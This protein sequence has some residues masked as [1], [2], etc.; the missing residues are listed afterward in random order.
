MGSLIEPKFRVFRHST[1]FGGLVA[2]GRLYRLRRV[3]AL[4][5]SCVE[6][7]SDDASSRQPARSFATV[8]KLMVVSL[9]VMVGAATLSLI[10]CAQFEDSFGELR[11]PVEQSSTPTISQYRDPA[12]SNKL[13][14]DASYVETTRDSKWSY[15]LSGLR[16]ELAL[17]AVTQ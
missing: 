15:S 13:S 1:R 12:R 14:D 7:R 4:F 11:G 16:L 6:I 9:S 5:E 17:G 10:G 2:A 3:H 8:S